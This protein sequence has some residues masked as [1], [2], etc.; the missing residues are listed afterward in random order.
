MKEM[1][2]CPIHS[3]PRQRKGLWQALQ[4]ESRGALLICR[5]RYHTT[6]KWLWQALQRESRGA[7]ECYH[8]ISSRRTTPLYLEEG[9]GIITIVGTGDYESLLATSFNNIQELPA[10][11]QKLQSSTR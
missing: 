9:K 4:R 3:H 6:Q 11:Q 8:L 5:M 7:Y 1:L 10:D 2:L